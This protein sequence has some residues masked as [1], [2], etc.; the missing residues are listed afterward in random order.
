MMTLIKLDHFGVALEGMFQRLL[1]PEGD[2]RFRKSAIT[3][4]G[5]ICKT[6]GT[7]PQDHKVKGMGLYTDSAGQIWYMIEHESVAEATQ[8][9]KVVY[10]FENTTGEKLPAGRYI[11]S[12][13][14]SNDGKQAYVRVF[15]KEEEST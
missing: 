1:K 3:H 15:S 11:A 5:A 6:S 13:D 9:D 8:Q 14:W 2:K 7:I 10:H 12:L 4:L